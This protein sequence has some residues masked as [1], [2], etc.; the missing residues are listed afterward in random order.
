MPLTPAE[1]VR[2]RYRQHARVQRAWAA[3][4]GPTP[5]DFHYDAELQQRLDSSAARRAQYGVSEADYVYMTLATFDSL[6]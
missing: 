4:L 2:E 1:R 3:L 6:T 5:P